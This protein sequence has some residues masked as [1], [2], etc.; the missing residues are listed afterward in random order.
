MSQ[1]N[2][3]ESEIARSMLDQL[4]EDSRLY[5]KGTDYQNLLDFVVRLR[6]FAPFNALLLQIQKP[7]LHHAASARDWRETFGRTIRD[8]ARPLLILWPFGPVALVYDLMD[9]EGEDLPTG[10]AAFAATGVIDHMALAR[11]AQ[12]I[13]KKNITWNKVDAGDRKAGSIEL[14]KRPE[15]AGEASCYRMNINKNH[16]PNVQFATLAHELAHLYLGHLGRDSFLSIPDRPPQTLQQREL[17]AESTAYI[18][19][20]RNG[21]ANQSASYLANYVKQDTTTEQLDMYQIM[22]AA[23][24]VE[25]VLGLAARTKVDRPKKKAQQRP[26]V[27]YRFG[28]DSLNLFCF[29]QLS[30]GFDLNLA[31]KPYLIKSMTFLR[32]I[33]QFANVGTPVKKTEATPMMANSGDLSATSKP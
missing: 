1:P 29:Y 30:T 3:I 25:T 4:L 32:K 10:I 27:E 31:Q 5:H 24:Q 17:E 14:L 6:N 8:G 21:V 28:D 22:R 11:F 26:N 18:V 16:E 15:K 20:A 9:T 23:G 13:G 33:D 12:L 2:P 19:C 7:G